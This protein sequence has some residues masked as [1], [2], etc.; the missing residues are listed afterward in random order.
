M[1]IFHFPDGERVGGGDRLSCL[2]L[3]SHVVPEK[4]SLEKG[5]W[6]KLAKSENVVPT[7][8]W[9]N[10]AVK[11]DGDGIITARKRSLGR[12]CFYTCLSVILFTG[13]G[14]IPAYIAGGIPACLVA[15]LWGRG[16]LCIPACT[17]ADP[18]PWTA[19]GAAGTHRTVMHSC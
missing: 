15:I 6:G 17:E 13:G 7:Y 12:L 14:G 2:N 18:P 11:Q 3:K 10:T 8:V 4:F 5:G 1:R 19:T 9:C 16:R